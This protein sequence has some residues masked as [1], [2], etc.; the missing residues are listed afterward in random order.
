VLYSEE[1][2]QIEKRL[3]KQVNLDA[4]KAEKKKRKRV[5]LGKIAMIYAMFAHRR[6]NKASTRDEVSFDRKDADGIDGE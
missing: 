6:S 5:N 4:A 3:T 1:L 2:R